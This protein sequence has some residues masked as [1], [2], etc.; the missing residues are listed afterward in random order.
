[1]E[2]LEGEQRTNLMSKLYTFIS[3]VEPTDLEV[4][5]RTCSLLKF[6]PS[7]YNSFYLDFVSTSVPGITTKY[8]EGMVGI[9][10]LEKVH[11]FFMCR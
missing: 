10:Q 7:D 8:F 4:L 6:L 1:M 3:S 5:G 2:G 9:Y 11:S